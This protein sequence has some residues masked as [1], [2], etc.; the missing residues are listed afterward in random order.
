MISK[1]PSLSKLLFAW[2]IGTLLACSAYVLYSLSLPPDELLMA[3]TLEFQ[4]L[5]SIVFVALP[6]IFCLF[7]GLLAGAVLKGRIAARN[8]KAG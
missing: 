4:A 5:M 7:V 1:W 2:G 6:S 3:N 8:A